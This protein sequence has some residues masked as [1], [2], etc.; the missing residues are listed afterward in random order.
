MSSYPFPFL[1]LQLVFSA[2]LIWSCFCR[3]V[4][5]DDQ[6]IREVRLAIW[7]EGVAAMLLM[8]APV[9]PLVSPQ[10]L[11]WP[12]FTT[13]SWVWLVLLASAMLVQVV[14]SKHWKHGTPTSFLKDSA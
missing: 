1:L 9:L 5:T 14:T 11:N 12:A 8:S 3:L 10:T 6:T 4:V 2:V 7:L 13:P